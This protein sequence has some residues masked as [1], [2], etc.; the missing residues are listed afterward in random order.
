[1]MEH[2]LSLILNPLVLL[3]DTPPPWEDPEIFLQQV[4]T[5]ASIGSIYAILGLAVVLIYRSTGIVNFA[6]G[7]MAMFTTFISW[8]FLLRMEFWPAFFLT[9]LVA[10]AIGAALEIVVMRPVER[11]PPL[12]SVVV[13]LGLFAIFSS[14][15]LWRYG[16]LPRPFETPGIFQGAPLEVGE[17]TIS[18]LNVG[19]LSIAILIMLL[20]FL[21]FNYTKLGL[22]MRA[23]AQNP[24]A[25]RLV[26]INTSR[27]LALGWG[28]SAAVGAIA[29][30]LTAASQALS[31]DMMLGILIFAFAGAVLG[32]LDSPGGAI[33]G[34]ISV[35]IIK[36]LSA[37]YISPQVDI[38]AAF[39][40]IIAVLMVRPTGLFGKVAIRRV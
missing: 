4:A 10:F 7:E 30:M 2:L 36:S 19:I 27:M 34:G 31:V 22:A 6:Q 21:L 25:S 23:T 24:A 15:A 5:G 33:I 14:L 40:V 37:T 13:T 17:V 35:G 3:T 8:S 12:N 18:R 16:P 28:L 26:G 32:G 9:T 20:L 39:V 38:I 11:A 1:M 29:G